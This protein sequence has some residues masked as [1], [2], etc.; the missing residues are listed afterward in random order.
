LREAHRVIRILLDEGTI[1]FEG[2]FFAYAGVSTAARRVQQHV[3]VKFGA[4][5]GLKSMQLA[6]EIADGLHTACAYSAE[7]LRYAV[8]HFTIGAARAARDADRLDLGDSLLGGSR[9]T[10][11]SRAAPP[12]SWPLSISPP[13]RPPCSAGTASTPPR[14]RP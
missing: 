7:A 14:W 9:P 2:E 3:P 10:Q 13:C 8:H 11:T 1:D 6:D 4:M 12:A 5:G